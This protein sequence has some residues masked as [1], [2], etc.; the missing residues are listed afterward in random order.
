MY[1]SLLLAGSMLA[2]GQGAS[3]PLVAREPTSETI[4]S[5][6]KTKPTRDLQYHDC[7]NGFQCARLEVPLDWSQPTKNLTAAIAIVKLPATVPDDDPSFGGS[8]LINPGGPGG[9]GSDLAFR[10]GH[11]FQ[12][13]LAGERN[14]EII[15]FD[16]RGINLT[17]PHG[18]CYKGDEVS[19]TL[20]LQRTS[21]ISPVDQAFGYHWA[22]AYAKSQLCEQDGVDSIWGHIN[23]ATVA[24]DM[25]EI[26][27]RIDE[28]R[29]KNSNK[30]KPKDAE[31]PRLQYLGISF[32]SYIGNVFASMFP[33]RVGRLM[34][35]AIVDPEDWATGTLHNNINDAEAIVDYFH[36]ICFESGEDCPL[37]RSTDKSG[38]DIKNRTS[39]FLEELDDFPVSFA[40]GNR[41]VLIGSP[42]VRQVIFTNLYRP[43]QQFELLA[44]GLHALMSG[45]Y[46]ALIDLLYPGPDEPVSD[47]VPAYTWENEVL[48]GVLCTDSIDD[49]LDRNK[50]YYQD[51]VAFFKKQSPTVGASVTAAIPFQCVGRKIRSPYA[52]TGPFKSP[53]VNS[54]DP[55]APAAPLLI[56]TTQLDPITPYANAFT[57]QKAHPGSAVV[58]QEGVGHGFTANPSKCILDIIR[59]YFHTGKVPE[60]G[61]VCEAEC[62]ATIPASKSNCSS[63]L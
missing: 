22:A 12:T 10:N 47:D 37:F 51:A 28:L 55:K 57:V 50:S 53:A 54:N 38:S 7:G 32:G 11:T 40:Y 5:W 6:T 46:S 16:P 44:S 58:V 45:N 63:F 62:F 23:T 49:A 19:R 33:E 20:D 52:F 27:D 59:E 29:W 41:T 48:G 18:D 42:T 2:L 25:V 13:V 4:F 30:T 34:I 9:S 1:S 17:T 36:K 39:A 14:Y 35:D 31:K 3:L 24:R 56:T 43:L 26:I 61:T 21:G 8:V 60:N 15:G